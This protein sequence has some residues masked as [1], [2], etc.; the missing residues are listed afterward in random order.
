MSLNHILKG[1]TDRQR[2]KLFKNLKDIYD[3]LE[4]DLNGMDQPCTQC[5]LCCNFAEFGHKL[6]ICSLEFA[7]VSKHLECDKVE[8]F[9]TCPYMKEKLCSA[10]SYRMLGCRTFFRLHQ[11][12]DSIQAQDLYEKYL[13]QI[14]ELYKTNK[15]PWEYKDFMVFV[16]EFYC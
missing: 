4:Q 10:R 11:D 12:K 8:N 15:I 6:Y 14:K 3:Q 16:K 2:E 7:Y 13:S 9:Q 5:G 1:I